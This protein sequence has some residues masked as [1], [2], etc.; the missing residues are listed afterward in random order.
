M[1]TFIINILRVTAI[2]PPPK[3]KE[4]EPRLRWVKDMEKEE[5]EEKARATLLLLSVTTPVQRLTP[6]LPETTFT[7]ASVSLL[8]TTTR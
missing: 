6:R 4:K 7:P 5:K 8:P 1:A 2:S 3:A